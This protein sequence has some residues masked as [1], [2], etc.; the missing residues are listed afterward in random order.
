MSIH[1]VFIASWLENSIPMW[2]IMT[3]FDETIQVAEGLMTVRQLVAWKQNT[4]TICSSGRIAS[5]PNGPAREKKERK[6][7]KRAGVSQNAHSTWV[8]SLSRDLP[9]TQMYFQLRLQMLPIPASD[10]AKSHVIKTWIHPSVSMHPISVSKRIQLSAWRSSWSALYH[11]T[12]FPTHHS[13]LQVLVDPFNSLPNEI[14]IT[15]V[16]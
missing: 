11:M 10:H 7:E 2:T 6:K 12:K 4:R 8:D 1:C 16:G 9:S 13:A 15:F 5:R 14:Q 3:A